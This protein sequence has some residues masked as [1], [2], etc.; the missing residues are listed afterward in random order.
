MSLI[1]LLENIQI[2]ILIID[3]RISQFFVIIPADNITAG[4]CFVIKSNAVVP[5]FGREEIESALIS[6]E[7]FEHVIRQ[8]GVP[9][10]EI[11]NIFLQIRVSIQSNTVLE[12]RGEVVLR[13]N[14]VR[15]VTAG[16]PGVVRHRFHVLILY[17]YSHLI[18]QI[19]PH[20]H[21]F[22]IAVAG[23]CGNV[24]NRQDDAVLRRIRSFCGGRTWQLQKQ[25]YS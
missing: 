17:L 4:A 2:I 22:I 14:N 11:R 9:L 1:H 5:D 16:Q 23:T 8:P 21:I 15:Q 20:A 7:L 3:G 19:L 13:G 24:P 10:Q 12:D 25:Q 6:S 18:R